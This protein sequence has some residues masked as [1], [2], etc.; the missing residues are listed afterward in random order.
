MTA[1]FVGGVWASSTSGGSKRLQKVCAVPRRAGARSGGGCRPNGG[2][3]ELSAVVW[4]R[5]GCKANEE[6]LCWAKTQSTRLHCVVLG[7]A[8]PALRGLGAALHRF[9]PT[10][11]PAVAIGQACAATG[12]TQVYFGAMYGPD[13][14]REELNVENMC[15]RSRIGVFKVPC[16]A[17]VAP[18]LATAALMPVIS[19]KREGGLFV[20][21]MEEDE[22]VT[23]VV[24]EDARPA[25]EKFIDFIYRVYLPDG[26]PSSVTNDYLK[27]TQWRI[28]QNIAS[29]VMAVI[30]TEA[31]LFGLGIGKKG[32][33]VAAATSWVLKDGLGYI[34]KVLYGYL[35]GKQFDSDP[36][37]WRVASDAVEDLGGVLE[38]LTPLSPSNFLLLASIANMMKGVSGMTG[39]ATRHAIYKSLALRDNQGDIAT[40]GESQGVTCKML[41]LGMGI[42]ISSAIGQNYP[43]LLGAYASFAVI[44]LLGNWQ[45]MKCVQFSTLNRQRG[46]IVINAFLDDRPIPNPYEVSHIETVMFPPW[47][48]YNEHVV[49]GSTVADAGVSKADVNDA[50]KL[51]HSRK[52][53]AFAKKKDLHVLFRPDVGHEEV[54]TAYLLAHRIE[55]NGGDVHEAE[56]YIRKH[57]KRFHAAVNDAGWKTGSSIFLLNVRN[58]RASW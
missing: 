20:D 17:P 31:L 57:A 7:E 9:P 8:S 26:F 35:A 34:G 12:A 27:F 43:V 56:D 28:L 5:E 11:D 2:G 37:S 38:L 54:L 19:E 47:K 42:A 30:S 52:Y 40:K 4:W 50:K 46:S 33:A 32:S 41:G 16:R 45:S 14:L 55:R 51:F 39:T 53:L 25:D 1:A 24:R 10:V 36:K 13:A 15:R 48:K 18:M 21:Y 58:N 6:A 3:R 29:S 44:H 23:A 49:L 22:D